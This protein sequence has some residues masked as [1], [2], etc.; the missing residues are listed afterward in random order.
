MRM[1]YRTTTHLLIPLQYIIDC[2]ADNVV[3][4]Q[5]ATVVVDDTV[6]LTVW[7]DIKAI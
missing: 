5:D 7:Y 4:A 2:R 6:L 3:L 1:M